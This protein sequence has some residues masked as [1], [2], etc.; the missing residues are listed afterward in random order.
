[1]FATT[2]V[3]PSAQKCAA[4]PRYSHVVEKDFNHLPIHQREPSHHT[5]EVVRDDHVHLPIQERSST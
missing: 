1:M 2:Y 5:T 4:D 3:L